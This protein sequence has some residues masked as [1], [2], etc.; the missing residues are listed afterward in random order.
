MTKVLRVFVASPSDVAAERDIVA[1]AVEE[2]NRG[3][4]Q[5][6]GVRLEL[7]RWETHTHPELGTDPQNVVNQQIGDEF[8]V[9][10]GI[11]WTRLGTR[12]PRSESGTLEEF[13]RAMERLKN[14]PGSIS[15]MLYFKEEP[16]SPSDIDPEQLRSV[17][18]FRKKVSSEGLYGTFNTEQEFGSNVRVHLARVLIA[19]TELRRPATEIAARSVVEPEI[20]QPRGSP[21]ELQEDEEEVVEEGFLDLILVGE[22]NLQ[23]VVVV[24]GNMTVALNDLGTQVRGATADL[25]TVDPAKGRGGTKRAKQIVNRLAVQLQVIFDR[26]DVEVLAF[27]G[28]FQNAMGA[29]AK[30]MVI[31]EDFGPENKE[32]VRQNLES[33]DS[34][35][36]ALQPAGESVVELRETIEQLPRITTSFNRAKRR[37]ER[38][39]GSVNREFS[40]AFT[41][42]RE[43]VELARSR[44]NHG[45]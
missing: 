42:A 33:I 21:R 38:V 36:K 43:V 11:L 26:L 44:I 2:V 3:T 8:E 39:L 9:F 14:D 34:L 6:L 30:S 28:R 35:A 27:Q 23:A 29:I 5:G 37:S 31:V 1:S 40:A 45:E 18:K 19:R 7:V 25:G 17:Q 13:E 22:E 24:L 4:G 10:L 12:T 16:R 41:L 32:A 15:V 20:P